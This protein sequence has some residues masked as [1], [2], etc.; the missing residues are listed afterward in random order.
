MHIIH[1]EKG[2]NVYSAYCYYS[3]CGTKCVK[4]IYGSTLKEVA[5]LCL[6]YYMLTA[7]V[8]SMCGREQLLL[9]SNHVF[10]TG[11]KRN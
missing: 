3:Y 8:A 10:V 2:L 6:V 11:V 9:H 7:S 4:L 5:V 1:N